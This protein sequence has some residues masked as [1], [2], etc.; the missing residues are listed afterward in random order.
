MIIVGALV[1]TSVSVGSSVCDG[2]TVGVIL[3]V[4]VAVSTGV[5]LGIDVFVS[6]GVSLG[7]GELVDS[8]VSV[9]IVVSVCWLVAEGTGVS[10]G[11][12]RVGDGVN[13]GKGVATIG[14]EDVA[15]S[16]GGTVSV[17]VAVGL[18]AYWTAAQPPQ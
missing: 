2:V 9:G 4:V 7:T 3:G 1:G 18:F 16:T 17:G 14:T 11:P 5:S 15:V 10:S 13:V 8:G 6:N 12:I